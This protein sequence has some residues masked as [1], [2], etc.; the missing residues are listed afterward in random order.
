MTDNI[1]LCRRLIA[2]LRGPVLHPQYGFSEHIGLA[3]TSS[4]CFP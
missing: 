4:Y 3:V 2:E 1:L